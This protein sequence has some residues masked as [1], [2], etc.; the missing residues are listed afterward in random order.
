[1]KHLIFTIVMITCFQW[2]ITYCKLTTN[3]FKTRREFWYWVFPVYPVI[4]EIFKSLIK[5]YMKLER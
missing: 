4:L 2:F 1:M 5:C 3:E